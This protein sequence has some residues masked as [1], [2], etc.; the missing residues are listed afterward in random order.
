M[1]DDVRRMTDEQLIERMRPR[2]WEARYERAL[3]SDAGGLAGLIVLLTLSVWGSWVILGRGGIR[4]GCTMVGAS[5][6]GFLFWASLISAVPRWR[7]RNERRELG[8]RYGNAPASIYE[9]AARQS[10][11]SERYDVVAIVLYRELPSTTITFVRLCL[12]NTGDSHVELRRSDWSLI[13]DDWCATAG[14]RN[15]DTAEVERLRELLTQP[16]PSPV[17]TVR[18]VKDGS[19][20]K[21]IVLRADGSRDVVQFNESEVAEDSRHAGVLFVR[22]IVQTVANLPTR[23]LKLGSPASD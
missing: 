22:A 1:G 14:K 12:R 4:N 11:A 6:I 15:L 17:P 10:I 18:K 9:E 16:L 13:Q 2:G 8:R 20:V 19:P 3:W 7:S 5:L 21:L 23:T